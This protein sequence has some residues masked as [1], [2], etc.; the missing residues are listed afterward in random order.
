MTG[1][2]RRTLFRNGRV[3]GGRPSRRPTALAVEEG[4]VVWT[5]TE[6]RASSYA[7]ADEVVDLAGAL[8]A[9]AFVDAHVHTVQAGFRLTELDLSGTASLLEALDRLAA[10]AAARPADAVVVGQGWDETTW[11]EG[12]V[13][14]GQELA[15]AADGRRVYLSRVDGHSSVVSPALAE[16]VA[17]IAAEDGWTP[18]GRAERDAHHAIRAVLADLVGPAERLA[19]ARAACREMAGHGVVGFHENAA[20]HIGPDYELDLVRQAAAE[21]GLRATVY[22]GE[23]LAVAKAR[24]L[25]VQ[26]LC[27]DLVAD[28]ALGSRT[29]ALH[30]EYADRPGHHGHAYLTAEEVA[31]HVVTCTQAGL[32]A[33]FHCIGDAA[34]DA[35]ADGFEAAER[36]LGTAPLQTGRHRLEHVEMP[37]SRVVEILA[38]LGVTASVQPVFDALW[39]GSELMYAARLGERWRATNPFLDLEMAGVRLAFGSDSPVTPIGP[40]QAVRAAVFHHHPDHRLP[41]SLAFRA[42]TRGGWRAAGDDE[43]GH[44]SPG[45][46]ADLAVWE[47]PAGL[48]E[49]GLPDLSPD[50]ELP[51]LVRT[52]SAGRTIHQASR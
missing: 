49:D 17:G 52:V 29:A 43:A 9:P 33:G 35:V 22:W 21:A 14:T 44:L 1:T 7:G 19:A 13:P 4:R 27:G 10:H 36:V 40:W 28:G 25:G 50:A 8:L 32:Q 45:S 41:T 46:R 16:T 42:H 12:R 30:Q 23:L 18:D 34:L 5:G 3:Y 47:T 24:E 39:G 15:R 26:G 51:A 31:E 20:P 38:R 2:V 48:D 11:A 6:D 37:S